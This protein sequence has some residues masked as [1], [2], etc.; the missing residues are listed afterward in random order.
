MRRF[1]KVLLQF[2]DA[3]HHKLAEHGRI[4][5]FYSSLLREMSD[6]PGALASLEKGEKILGQAGLGNDPGA[7][8]LD[9]L[10]IQM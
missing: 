5:L 3:K 6:L 8:A 2:P 10:I 7:T 4:L 1:E 9:V